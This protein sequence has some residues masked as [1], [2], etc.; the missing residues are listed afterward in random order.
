MAD[1]R[2][3]SRLIS[4][5]AVSVWPVTFRPVTWLRTPK[6]VRQ[7]DPE[8]YHLTFVRHGVG[9]VHWDRQ[10][11]SYTTR[12]FHAND[13]SRAYV[14]RP[15][16]TP[17]VMIG[18]EVP[19]NALPMPRG[20]AERVIGLPMSSG[21]GTGALLAQFLTGLVAD[22]G[23][24]TPADGPRLGA[25]TADLVAALFAHTLEAE[26]LLRPETRTRALTLG[27]KAFIQRRLDDPDLTPASIAAAH[28]ISRSYLY[29]LF[30]AEDDSV[31]GYVRRL[32]LEA[33]GRDLADPAQHGVPIH[34]VAVRWCFPRPSEFT[35]AFRAAF[36]VTPT[37]HRQLSQP[38]HGDARRTVGS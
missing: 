24:Y 7:S 23:P 36:G 34:A 10:E 4:L 6:L 26:E 37:E 25:I 5:G 9:S 1:F 15:G 30:A 22:T 14:V 35:R 3:D 31:A 19:K 2:A 16:R 29:R 21:Q 28:H 17:I 38:T 8:T 11:T 32:R 20:R 18:V 33:A 13:S 27:I 12:D